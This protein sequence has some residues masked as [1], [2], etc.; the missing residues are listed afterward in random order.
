MISLDLPLIS[1]NYAQS[2]CDPE[3]GRMGKRLADLRMDT[4]LEC[5]SA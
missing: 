5:S 4:G 1:L 2:N 3:G